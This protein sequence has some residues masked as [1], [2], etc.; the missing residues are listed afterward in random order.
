M[1]LIPAERLRALRNDV[2]VLAVISQ[3]AIAKKMR[4]RRLAFRCPACGRFHT[5]TQPRTNLARC[6]ACERNF[7]PIDL[8]MAERGWSFLQAVT[9]LEDRCDSPAPRRVPGA[10][11]SSN[12]AGLVPLTSPSSLDW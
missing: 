10:G 7:N 1:S 3:L 4:G 2:P 12:S 5:A 8:V 6:F 11:E 9:Y